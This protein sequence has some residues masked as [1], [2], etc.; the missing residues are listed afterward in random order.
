MET[1]PKLLANSD[2]AHLPKGTDMASDQ[3]MTRENFGEFAKANWVAWNFIDKKAEYGDEEYR[4]VHAHLVSKLGDEY[5]RTCTI[6]G[7]LHR[8]AIKSG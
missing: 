4:N 2:T 6:V 7:P 1:N 5:F 3:E 8:P